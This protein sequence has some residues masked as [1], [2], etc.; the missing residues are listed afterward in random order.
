MRLRCLPF[1]WRR[2]R[3]V[4]IGSLLAA[5]L[6]AAGL[7]RYHGY[8]L[9]DTYISFR[10]ARNLVAGNGLVYNPGE[11]VEGYTNFLHVIL[12]AGMLR[13]GMDPAAA[14]P[15]I[16]LLAAIAA[17]AAAVRLELAM[18]GDAPRR[19][20]EPPLSPLLLLPLPAFAYWATSAMETMLFTALVSL[21]VA[22]ALRDD[23]P[24]AASTLAF[25]AAA[26][27]RPEG[28]LWFGLTLVALFL[29]AWWRDGARPPLAASIRAAA[30]FAALY[31]AYFGWRLWY[32][33]KLVPN[34]FTAKVTGGWEQIL[35]GARHL[36]E[37]CLGYPVLALAVAAAPLG[38]AWR[39]RRAGRAPAVSISVLA[40]L[41][42][43]WILYVVAVGGDFM[44]FFR[45]FIPALPIA[46]AIAATSIAALAERLA[47]RAT[48]RALVALTAC[49]LSAAAGQVGPQGYRAFVASRTAIVG[50]A[51]GEWMKGHLPAGS[52]IA[53]NTAGALPYVSELPA[54]DMLGL[55][56]EN[57]ASRPV[58]VVS[59]G[60]AG[61]RRGWGTYVLDRR[62]DAI[63]WYNASGSFDP[64]YLS[65]REMAEDPVFRFFYRPR[66][67]ALP[68]SAEA[69]AGDERA[70]ETFF[71]N[72]FEI[73]AAGKAA[74][75]DLGLLARLTPG[76]VP[77]TT[78]LPGPVR[79]EYFELDA[80]LDPL[81]PSRDLAREDF[82]AFLGRAA[83]L[84]QREAA[85]L[86][87]PDA[88]ARAEVDRLCDAARQAVESR[89]VAE[90][91]GLLERAEGLNGPARSAL[92][93]QYLANLAVLS[94]DR[95]AALT[96]QKEAM[97]L[98]PGNPLHR[99]NLERLFK[100]PRPPARSG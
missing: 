21:S 8:L 61:H 26:L 60:W 90:A 72:P 88:A 70:I 36:G 1:A 15:W 100:A 58:F 89:K 63:V 97:R 91:R 52:T 57:I 56:D 31:G 2:H 44:P 73:G 79:L 77:T 81:W 83:E 66:R 82:G 11:K 92:V 35:T 53:V 6:F 69:G 71:G 68:A 99:A 93:Y 74:A 22:L 38:V 67:V 64:Y 34:T 55:T 47:A 40:M 10:Y 33:G 80:R 51:A 41:P 85:S 75:P 86:P 94:G 27:T 30:V 13:A 95:L 84:W 62:P 46:A 78:F 7:V 48:P 5:A 65:D 4:V 20:A 24:G 39:A 29:C 96:A 37:W 18:R 28:G 59:A 54:I 87:P 16:S 49:L 76:L 32:Y 25:V 19:R 17:V 43:A 3:A 14:L 98:A 9:D 42:I 45:F 12:S 50:E 23:R